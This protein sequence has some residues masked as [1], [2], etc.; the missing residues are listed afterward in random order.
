MSLPRITYRID[1]VSPPFDGGARV[2]VTID[3]VIKLNDTQVASRIS[4]CMLAD[5][6]SMIQPGTIWDSSFTQR[7]PQ[8]DEKTP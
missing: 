8:Q 5:K 2:E 7:P 3:V 1:K 4:H 6:A